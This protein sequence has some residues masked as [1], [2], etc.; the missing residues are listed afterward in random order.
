MKISC[1]N[2]NALSA[3]AIAF[4]LSAC[5][6]PQPPIV[7]PNALPQSARSTERPHSE[8]LLYVTGSTSS[9]VLVFNA[10][11]KNPKPKEQITIGLGETSGDCIDAF[12][13]L[14]VVNT[15]GKGWISEYPKGQRRPSKIIR[16][17]IGSPVYC[18][19]DRAGDLWVT[20]SYVMRYY[21]R[22]GP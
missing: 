9:T 13:T 20:N 22:S 21:R 5:G 18:A 15:T 3:I 11:V 4:A 8:Q 10:Q 1:W 6:G 17:G 16:K 12:G 19:I 2:R 14:Y 7:T